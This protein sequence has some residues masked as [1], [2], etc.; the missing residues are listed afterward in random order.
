MQIKT[1]LAANKLLAPSPRF[2]GNTYSFKFNDSAEQELKRLMRLNNLD[3]ASVMGKALNTLSVLTNLVQAGKGIYTRDKD[4]NW[5]EETEITGILPGK[6][7]D[8]EA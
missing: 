5:V 3:P 1:A 8:T 6:R 7:I 4:A 2:Q